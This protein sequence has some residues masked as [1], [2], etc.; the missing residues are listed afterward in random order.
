M[1]TRTIR[2]SAARLR[3]TIESSGARFALVSEIESARRPRPGSWSRKEIVG[4]LV[5]SASNNHQRFVRAQFQDDLVFPGYAQDDWVRAQRYSDEPWGDLLALWRAFNLHI[6]HVM[7]TTP[8]NELL[9]PRVRHNLHEIAWKPVS[10]RDVVT[11]EWFMVD[12]VGHFEH[13]VNQ[14]LSIAARE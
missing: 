14:A 13:H 10:A 12:Y 4:H 1:S 6:A 11:L 8:E 9:R 2:E 7:E 3:A 5:D